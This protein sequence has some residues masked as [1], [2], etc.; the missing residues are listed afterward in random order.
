MGGQNAFVW[1][2]NNPALVHCI[3]GLIPVIDL[4]DLRDNRGY[5]TTIVNPRQSPPLPRFQMESLIQK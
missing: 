3:V 2:K 4:A 5:G 1:A